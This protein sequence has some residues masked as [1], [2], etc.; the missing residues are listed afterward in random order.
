M[1]KSFECLYHPLT[2]TPH[3]FYTLRVCTS[4]GIN[5]IQRVIHCTVYV[6]RCWHSIHRTPWL[7]VICDTCNREQCSCIPMSNYYQKTA[8]ASSLVTFWVSSNT[9]LNT[10]MRCEIVIFYRALWESTI[11]PPGTKT[12]NTKGVIL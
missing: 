4:G 9:M 11:L 8:F 5:K 1:S 12:F 10:I 7:Y 2:C 6:S 3:A